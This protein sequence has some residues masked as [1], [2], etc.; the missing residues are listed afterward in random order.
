MKY[1]TKVLFIILISSYL[2]F[3]RNVNASTNQF[4]NFIAA[5]NDGGYITS[6]IDI[7]EYN[8]NYYGV[9]FMMKE[10]IQGI[11]YGFY[12][13]PNL[14]NGLK[15]LGFN[16]ET[17]IED[18]YIYTSFIYEDKNIEDILNKL[19]I[20][21][22]IDIAAEKE[23]L[24][25]NLY[26]L[27]QFIDIPTYL[28]LDDEITKT[29]YSTNK[30]IFTYTPSDRGAVSNADGVVGKNT[31]SWTSDG[32]DKKII[33]IGEEN[34]RIIK[35]IIV[36]IIFGGIGGVLLFIKTR[37]NNKDNYFNNDYYNN[38]NVSNNDM[39]YNN[40]YYDSYYN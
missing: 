1:F 16:P 25:D 13:T 17:Y 4:E 20:I 8:R 3:P 37:K 19:S 9:N 7:T 11:D 34:N 32:S 40:G 22:F 12:A 15:T 28:E 31:F 6:Q 24:N 35:F 26:I 29:V 14:V 30:Y 38:Q 10:N 18:D 36:I 21:P 5:I 27:G 39:F 2:L 33:S 23:T